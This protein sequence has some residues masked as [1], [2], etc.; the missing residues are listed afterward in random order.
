MAIFVN[1]SGTLRTVRF[2]AI[3]DSGT[4]RRVNEVYVND[5]G[6][7]AGPFTATHATTRQTAT[8]TST[9][10]GVQNTVFNTTTTFDTDYILVKSNNV[11]L[12][13]TALISNDYQ[14][15]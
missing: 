13:T 5:N 10:S 14:I 2:I 12:A 3:N 4:I 6:S 11:S 8:T 15:I 1:D 9:I 7:L